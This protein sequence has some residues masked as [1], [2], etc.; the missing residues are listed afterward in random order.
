[1][2]YP[3]ILFITPA[4]FNRVTGGG[5]TFTN[6]FKGWPKDSIATLHTDTVPVSDETCERYYRI[7]ENEIYPIPPLNL[8]RRT[9]NTVSSN[10]AIV[11]Q[12][13]R[14]SALHTVKDLIFGDGLPETGVL[15]PQL[16][17]W[18]AEFR[19]TVIY[20]PLG[21]NGMMK[22][23]QAIRDRFS[24]PVVIH[25]MDDWQSAIYRGGI[26]SWIQR[27]T[28]RRL[29]TDLVT[30]AAVCLSICD[31]MGEVYSIQY[32][33]PFHS[34]QNTIDVDR[35]AP[36]PGARSLGH[37]I[38]VLYTG[39]ILPFAQL[40]SLAA[41]CNA[42]AQLHHD[43]WDIR[44]DIHSPG[45]QTAGIEDR[46]LV[47]D[48]IHLAETIADDSLYFS[49]LAQ[50][51]VLLLPANF[52]A[53]S[54]A[55]VGLSMPTKVPSYLTSGTPILVYGPAQLA[56]VDY[57]TREGWGLVIDTQ[58]FDQLKLGLKR[59]IEDNSL[60]DTLSRRAQAVAQD[61]HNAETVRTAFQTALQHA[62]IKKEPSR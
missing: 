55:Y 54:M 34:F 6:L 47:C 18:I 3:R 30:N 9:V 48:A 60:R 35:W 51:D 32:G 29:I 16:E 2:T 5:I 56:Q 25:I 46:L 27:R 4:A 41:C 52:D 49:T 17:R 39:S 36:P 58:D 57:A 20:T 53:H 40:D 45:F 12:N 11:P 44:L 8:V 62:A 38:R 19:P 42:V 31:R 15:S 28:M 37:P 7:S 14:K 24:L 50:A 10:A 22:I 23:I 43:G 61:R 33:V 13:G 59:I 21:P 1:M 26:L